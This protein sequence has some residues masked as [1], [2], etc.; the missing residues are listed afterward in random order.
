MTMMI[1]P[2]V[3]PMPT[4]L[5]PRPVALLMM[6]APVPA[7]TSPNVPTNSAASRCNAMTSL[8]NAQRLTSAKIPVEHLRGE[9][10]AVLGCREVFGDDQEAV[11][12]CQ[13]TQHARALT[14][15]DVRDVPLGRRSNGD[16]DVVPATTAVL[17][18][19]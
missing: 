15:G 17:D 19:A 18:P 13:R 7:K 4:W 10:G 12:F 14:A 1:R 16:P 3:N 11:R 8:L 2:K 5:T 6:M 9:H